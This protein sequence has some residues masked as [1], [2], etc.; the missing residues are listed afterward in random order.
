ME[1]Q[2]GCIEEEQQ[3]GRVW[4]T[5]CGSD[6]GCCV[7]WVG[8]Y[9]H[10][11]HY[12]KKQLYNRGKRFRLFALSLGLMEINTQVGDIMQFFRIIEFSW[13]TQDSTRKYFYSKNVALRFILRC[14]DVDEAVIE[15]IRSLKDEDR[16]AIQI[17][18]MEKDLDRV[19]SL[20]F[21]NGKLPNSDSTSFG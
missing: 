15:T 6:K 9:N 11:S 2:C 3:N 13:S 16:A 19:S 14:L 8:S 4:C 7:T 5:N 18:E 10:Q 12:K 17:R 1:C 21:I 20:L